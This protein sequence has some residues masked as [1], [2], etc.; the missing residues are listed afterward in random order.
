MVNCVCSQWCGDPANRINGHHA[1]C[2]EVREEVAPSADFLRASERMRDAEEK[3]AAAKRGLENAAKR[4][5]GTLDAIQDRGFGT[6]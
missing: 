1:N 2:A 3:L 5:R 6:A 4:S